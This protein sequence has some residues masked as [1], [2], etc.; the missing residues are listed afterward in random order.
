MNPVAVPPLPLQGVEDP[1][2]LLLVE[3]EDKDAVVVLVVLLEQLLQLGLAAP[4]VYHLHDLGHLL[5]GGKVLGADRNL[6][7][8]EAEVCLE[9]WIPSVRRKCREFQG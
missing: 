6:G 7:G 1:V 8:R 2:R 4:L 9:G 3:D 5:A